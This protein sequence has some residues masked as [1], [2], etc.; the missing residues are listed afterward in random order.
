M[1]FVFFD[2]IED[3]IVFS[4]IT[5]EKGKFVPIK[6]PKY[7]LF[8]GMYY[9]F[10]EYEDKMRALNQYCYEVAQ[11]VKVRYNDSL[12][13]L[14]KFKNSDN[15]NFYGKD[16]TKYEMV[17]SCQHEIYLWENI[18]WHSVCHIVSLL[19]SFLERAL[20]RL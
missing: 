3:N 16:F 8:N 10:T 13:D 11:I 4:Y 19:Y 17:M 18:V 15:R 6:T 2:D 20:K 12:D 5:D 7:N 9:P 1:K 14:E